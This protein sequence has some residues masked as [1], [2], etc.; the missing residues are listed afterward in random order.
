M[1]KYYAT[2]P[3]TPN[4]FLSVLL[5][6]RFAIRTSPSG[7]VS[8]IIHVGSPAGI[9]QH[10]HAPSAKRTIADPHRPPRSADLRPFDVARF[11]RVCQ[12]NLAIM[13]VTDTV[14]GELVDPYASGEP[15]DRLREN[16]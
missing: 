3:A 4:S 9:G 11:L 8:T 2:P 16:G 7:R 14:R 15:F 1:S 5:T 13:A 10:A 6:S 12:R